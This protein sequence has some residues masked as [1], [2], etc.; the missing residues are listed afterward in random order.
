MLASATVGSDY[1]I[2][3]DD[4]RDG[5]GS[6]PKRRADMVLRRTAG[7]GT[8]FSVGSIAWT[9]C[10]ADDD[11]NPVARVTE[12]ALRELARERPFEPTDG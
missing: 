3:P 11:S 5:P 8:V 9:G 4:V 2:W 12:N 6:A 1:S 10:L 7:G